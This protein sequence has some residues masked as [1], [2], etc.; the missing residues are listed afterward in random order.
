LEFFSILRSVFIFLVLIYI[1]GG[2]ILKVS[3]KNEMNFLERYFLRLLFGIIF[4]SLTMLFLL[5]LEKFSLNNLILTEIIIVLPMLFYLII[6]KKFRPLFDRKSYYKKEFKKHIILLFM[7][8]CAIILFQRPSE[9]VLSF[10]MDASNYLVQSAY[11]TKSDSI[12]LKDSQQDIYIKYFPNASFK[13]NST[14]SFPLVEENKREFPFPPLWRLVLTGAMLIGGIKF[15]LYIPLFLGL[16]TSVGFYILLGKIIRQDFYSYLGTALLLFSPLLIQYMRITTSEILTLYIIIGALVTFYLACEQDNS[17]L[18]IIAGIILSSIFLARGDS[19]FLYIGL[20]LFLFIYSFIDS[21]HINKKVLRYFGSA[22]IIGSFCFWFITFYTTQTYM[23]NLIKYPNKESNAN[24]LFLAISLFMIGIAVVYFL[25]LTLD[26]KKPEI[27]LKLNNL[28]ETKVVIFYKFI[29]ILLSIFLS[30]AFLL[31]LDFSNQ[32]INLIFKLLNHTIPLSYLLPNITYLPVIVIMFYIT[33]FTTIVGA[34]GIV[35][36]LYNKKEQYFMVLFLF[37]IISIRFAIDFEH[38]PTIYWASRRYLYN[39]LPLFVI[40]ATFGLEYLGT[41]IATK[42]KSILSYKI[43]L[44]IIVATNLLINNYFFTYKNE[45]HFVGATNSFDELAQSFKKSDVILIDGD[46]QWADAF[47][48]GFKYYY[49][50]ES[51]SPYLN[52]I[53]DDEVKNFNKELTM[54]NK[55]LIFI[56]NTFDSQKRIMKLFK[57]QRVNEKYIFYNISKNYQRQEMDLDVLIVA[58]FNG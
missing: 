45:I 28:Y 23:N 9:W 18:G 34:I 24:I 39:L 2:L 35:M 26:K 13:V 5:C 10:G 31:R 4:S 29:G 17:I 41:R 37:I 55:R 25:L 16:L 53:S 8:V 50:I 7:F 11:T 3:Y 1:P 56:T 46:I 49:Q 6:T 43:I 33:V 57:V 54:Q 38:S 48:Q 32:T 20:T 44:V 52:S 47:Q 27:A 14:N 19:L 51:L 42:K 15:S 58:D 12:F 30:W 40:T 21:T 22:F 36:I